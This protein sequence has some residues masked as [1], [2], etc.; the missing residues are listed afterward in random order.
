MLLLPAVLI[1]LKKN[2]LFESSQSGII[3]FFKRVKRISKILFYLWAS[4]S[5]AILSGANWNIQEVATSLV[6]GTVVFLL[7]TIFLERNN[8]SMDENTEESNVAQQSQPK[9]QSD[10]RIRKSL[11]A[12]LCFAPIALIGL[13]AYLQNPVDDPATGNQASGNLSVAIV[14]GFLAILFLLI[15]IR[16]PKT[17]TKA[18]ER[19]TAKLAKKELRRQQLAQQRRMLAYK[20]IFLSEQQI[21]KLESKVELPVVDT[22]VFLNQGEVAVYYS[23]ATRQETKNRVVGRTGG[24]SGGTVRIAKGFSVHTGGSSSRP[25]YGDVSTHYEGKMVL[26]NKRLIFLSDQKAFEVPY[27]SITAATAYSDGISIQSRSHTYTLILPKADLAVIAFDAVRTGEIPIANTTTYVANYNDDFDDDLDFEIESVDH[28]SVSSVDGME[29]HEFE[30]FSAELLRKN[31]FS[32]VR[33]TPGSGDQGVDILAEKGGIKY[34]IQCKNYAS[35][36]S[37]TPVQEVN[38]GKLFYNCHVGVVLTN[39][40]FTPGAKKLADA[41]GVLLWDRVELQK[42]MDIANTCQSL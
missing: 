39:S 3:L 12:G 15:S 2:P 16:S 25:I 22:P 6:S 42:M 26:T 4:T 41:T 27:T 20:G 40:T 34:A 30:Y 32:N 19:K 36:L 23:I 33:V 24:Y 29:G 7:P 11:V 9:K 1:E 14:F 28:A 21:R 35:A 13:V 31:G 17:K 18:M 8:F 37:N 5:L 38:A 10:K